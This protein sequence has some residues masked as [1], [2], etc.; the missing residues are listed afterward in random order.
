MLDKKVGFV[1]ALDQAARSSDF[2]KEAENPE[3]YILSPTLNIKHQFKQR[4]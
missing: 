1:G 3:F 2:S 4:P